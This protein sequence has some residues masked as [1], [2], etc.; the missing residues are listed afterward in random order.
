MRWRIKLNLREVYHLVELRS[1]RQGHPSYRII[2]QEMHRLLSAVHP[3]LLA[4]M[5]FV[6]LNN[7][8]L[9]RLA[10]EQRIDTK[11]KQRNQNQPLT[12]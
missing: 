11:L 12:S 1:S 3:A 8:A 9:E 6:D 4:K 2:A 7:Y 10:T 5:H